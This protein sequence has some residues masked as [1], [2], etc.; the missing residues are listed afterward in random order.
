M[1]KRILI[2]APHTDDGEFGCGASINKWIEMGKDVFYIAF[3]SAE[4]SVPEGFPK[5]IL[6]KEVE[7]ATKVLG[8]KSSNLILYDYPVR[9]FLSFRQEILE[10]MIKLEKE[11][12]PDLV[13]LPSSMDTH[14]DHQVIRQEGFRAFKK[15]SIIGYEMPY[16]NLTFSTTLFIKLEE[17][18][19]NK[20]IEALKSYKSQM[21]RIYSSK[22]FIKGLA[23]VRGRQIGTMYAE[24]FEVVRWII[25]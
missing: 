8:L 19:V 2:L 18:H 9:E 4:K 14:Q 6:K 24:A 15:K 16:N 23:I 21:H 12:K 1:Y 22:D 17:R 25:K 11:L 10:D 13:V 3:S 5:D 7:E 20:K